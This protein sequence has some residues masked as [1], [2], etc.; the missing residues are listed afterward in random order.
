MNC[1]D[2]MCSRCSAGK[3]IVVGILVLAWNYYLSGTF[4]A[5]DWPTF[6]GVLLVLKGFLKLVKPG[7]PHCEEKMPDKK[8]K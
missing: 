5:K 4:L 2:G 1:H 6:I 3:F 7:C 8:K